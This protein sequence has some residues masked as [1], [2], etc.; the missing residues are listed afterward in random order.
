MEETHL[1]DSNILVY[2]LDRTAGKKQELAQELVAEGF[3]GH[4]TALA[5]Q[6]LVESYDTLTRRLGVPAQDAAQL[7]DDL[8]AV[9]SWVKLPLTPASVSRAMGLHQ[10]LKKQFWDCLIVATMLENGITTIYTED[11]G[12]KGFPGIEVI[13]PFKA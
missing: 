8:I 2:A 3:R 6:N 5:V 12:F 4:A 11:E 9:Q 7:V 1:L 10:R 13:N